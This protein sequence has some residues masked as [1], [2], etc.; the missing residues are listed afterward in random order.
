MSKTRMVLVRIAG[1]VVGLL[2]VGVAVGVALFFIL[3]PF[4]PE[5]GSSWE[6][7]FPAF[8][9]F[10]A[11]VVMGT[12]G[13]ALG[14]TTTQKLLGQGSSFWRAL[15]G[16]VVGLVVGALCG[17]LLFLTPSVLGRDTGMVSGLEYLAA[18]IIALAAIV[19]GAVIGSGWK[20]KPQ[21]ASPSA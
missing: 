19:A 13:A 9:G 3:S 7:A 10:L 4:D 14:A 11:G 18:P 6:G 16:A 5:R 15:L 12:A 2:V 1:S 20:A 8:F 21:A 17:L